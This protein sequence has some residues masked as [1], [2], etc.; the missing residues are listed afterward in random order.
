[1]ASVIDSSFTISKSVVST[2]H[3]FSAFAL[4]GFVLLSVLLPLHI[5][6]RNI[7]TC[8][9]VIWIGLLCLNGF[10]NSIVWNHNVTDWAP[11][12]CD[13]SSRLVIGGRIG[14]QLACLCIARHLYLVTR[15]INTSQL[16][17]VR[18]WRAIVCDFLLVIGVPTLFMVISYIVQV[19]RFVIYEEIGCYF[20]L[21]NTQPSYPL[22]LIWP[23]LVSL[24]VVVYLGVTIR[25]LIQRRA[26]F[27]KLI[28]HDEHF[29]QLLTL[30]VVIVTCTFPYSL[31]VIVADATGTGNPVS[32][33]SGWDNLHGDIPHVV[34]V[35]AV[36]WQATI[37][38]Q[39]AALQFERWVHVMYAIMAFSFFGFTTEAKKSYRAVLGF[40]TSSFG[41]LAIYI[42]R[43]K[44]CV[45]RFSFSCQFHW[46]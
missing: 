5:K 43:S 39:V 3:V 12:W 4:I 33:W 6:A 29:F 11:V 46:S 24:N 21:D 27:T 38:V 10:V 44:E 31:W 45:S 32:P 40:L 9:L 42:G 14:V 18:P 8:A 2:N 22:R 23:F 36:E 1:M 34:K 41:T 13:I 17:Q 15:N 7:G 37:P 16:S 25:T 20:A 35:P 26:G 28:Q 30:A 19:L